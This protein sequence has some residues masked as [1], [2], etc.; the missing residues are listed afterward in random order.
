MADNCGEFGLKTRSREVNEICEYEYWLETET[1]TENCTVQLGQWTEWSDCDQEDCQRTRSRTGENGICSSNETCAAENETGTCRG[2]RGIHFPISHKTTSMSMIISVLVMVLVVGLAAFAGFRSRKKIQEYY[3]TNIGTRW[4]HPGLAD[5]RDRLSLDPLS[6]N[7]NTILFT[8]DLNL[9]TE[10]ISLLER[11]PQPDLFKEFRKV[12]Q[13]AKRESEVKPKMNFEDEHMM[14][15]RYRDMVAY[16]DNVISLSS[17]QGIKGGK[18]CQIVLYFLSVMQG[19]LQQHTSMPPQYLL[20]TAL[21]LLSRPRR[22][23]QT[24]FR[25]FG[26]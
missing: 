8:K 18:S 12:E 16:E 26:Q 24:L 17:E 9:K 11:E 20:K 21:R 1:Q 3:R 25:T 7:N 6:T 19:L 5:G 15:N 14:H 22:R 10:I 2:G 13:Q 4:Y 23:R